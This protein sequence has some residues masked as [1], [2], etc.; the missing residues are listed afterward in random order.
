MK[1]VINLNA[2][3]SLFMTLG[4]VLAPQAQAKTANEVLR[5][6]AAKIPQLIVSKCGLKKIGALD[7][8]RLIVRTYQT[9]WRVFNEG[10]VT[11][12]QG[13][14]RTWAIHDPHYKFVIINEFT[15]SQQL[16]SPYLKGIIP[17][18]AL[19]ESLREFGAPDENYET[20]LALDVVSS[21]CDPKP[22]ADVFSKASEGGVTSTG[23]GGNEHAALMK[24]YL[25][26]YA[27]ND[28]IWEEFGKEIPEAKK[29]NRH[30][31]VK[32][33]LDLQI[34]SRM[35]MDFANMKIDVK[36]LDG[37]RVYLLPRM[38]LLSS[39]TQLVAEMYLELARAVIEN[40]QP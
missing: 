28:K 15:L 38:P 33:I 7:M 25:L 14:G 17:V 13:K 6:E 18:M 9:E 24:R 26:E 4:I 16:E 23:G 21:T 29:W 20:A 30:N 10:F 34:E 1:L 3:S 32:V 19:H 22:F 35:D 2:L 31:L 27:L 5:P 39:S 11:D 8:D 36:L 40:E 12:R 37:K